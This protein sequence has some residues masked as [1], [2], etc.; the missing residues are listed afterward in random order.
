MLCRINES[1]SAFKSCLVKLFFHF[2][3]F[4][5]Y[6]SAINI[7][8]LHFHHVYSWQKTSKSITRDFQI[9]TT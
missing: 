7:Q 9:N 5:K 8:Y 1:N 2:Q 6:I 4:L 3:T